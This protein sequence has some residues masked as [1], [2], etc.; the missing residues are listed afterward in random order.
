MCIDCNITITKANA[1]PISVVLDQVDDLKGSALLEAKFA[2][3]LFSSP[4]PTKQRVA[5]H[6]PR[7]EADI[8][9]N[10]NISL[11]RLQV[12]CESTTAEQHAK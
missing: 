12:D 10:P 4:I 3:V 5:D 6:R 8:E 9:M 2:I 7:V 1:N 11:Q